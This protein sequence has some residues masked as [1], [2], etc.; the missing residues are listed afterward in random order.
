MSKLARYT[1]I[2]VTTSHFCGCGSPRIQARCSNTR[3]IP[4]KTDKQQHAPSNLIHQEHR[5]DGGDQLRRRELPE[6]RRK[7]YIDAISDTA[8][9][10]AKL[11]SQLLTFSRRGAMN[12]RVFDVA[13]R[14]ERVTEM[15][16]TILGPRIS[17]VLDVSDRPLPV[18]ADLNQFETALVNL[19]ANA[20]DAMEGAGT[21]RIQL[22]SARAAAANGSTPQPTGSSRSRSAIPAAASP[23]TSRRFSSRFTTKE[24][25]QGTGLGL[26]QVYGFAKQ[27]GGSV[28]VQS[29]VGQGTTITLRLPRSEK[30][31]QPSDDTVS[32]ARNAPTTRGTVLVVEDNTEVGE[33]A[34][35]LLKDLGY[36]TTL[37]RNAEEALRLLDEDADRFR[38]RVQRR[39]HARHGWR[40]ARPEIRRRLSHLPF[41]LTSGYSNVLAEEGH[42][43]FEL[44]QK[45]YSVE[46]LS[47]TLRQAMKIRQ[48]L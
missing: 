2:S 31:V 41:V 18:E 23:A 11:T 45:P 28:T 1:R 13:D 37:A 29:E 21:L 30:P 48:S 40:I 34:S 5:D 17:L 43:D 47:R 22:T 38:H 9:R 3:P 6:D 20:R 10:A 46:D 27:S 33:F 16:G 19:A 8:D 25:G 24:V 4:A 14:L 35:Q 42:G 26:S 32:A 7:K 36:Q 44:L 15:L 39:R 12:P